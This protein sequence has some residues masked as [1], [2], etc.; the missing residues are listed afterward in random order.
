LRLASST[1]SHHHYR[2]PSK[3]GKVTIAHHAS[4]IIS[5]KSTASIIKQAG[6]TVDQFR[7]LL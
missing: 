4:Q 2:H 7:A 1:G 5:P 3:P 6:L